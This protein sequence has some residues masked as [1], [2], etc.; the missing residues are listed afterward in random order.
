ML[1]GIVSIR[2]FSDFLARLSHLDF[3]KI[4]ECANKQSVP[5]LPI[6]NFLSRSILFPGFFHLK[7]FLYGYFSY[8][9]TKG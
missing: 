3:L 5:S 4:E 8:N 6:L 1:D 7:V 9:F 2:Q